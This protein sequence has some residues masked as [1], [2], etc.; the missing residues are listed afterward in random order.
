MSEHLF[1]THRSLG[2]LCMGS[3]GLAIIGRSAGSS[4]IALT[5]DL[6]GTNHSLIGSS[7]SSSSSTGQAV[8]NDLNSL[9]S[10]EGL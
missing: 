8:L 7:S 2:S 4:G 5:G 10:S 9:Q 3:V 6:A 1:G